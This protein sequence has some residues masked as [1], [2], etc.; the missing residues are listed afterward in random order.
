MKKSY[1]M[2]T[3]FFVCVLVGFAFGSVISKT[4]SATSPQKALTILR[5]IGNDMTSMNKLA[6]ALNISYD[7]SME[8]KEIYKRL[9]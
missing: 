6:H 5:Q 3:G 7:L 1:C 4:P 9:N 8:F 2:D